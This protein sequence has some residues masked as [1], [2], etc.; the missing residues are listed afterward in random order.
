LRND[1]SLTSCIQGNRHEGGGPSISRQ[2]Q[3]QANKMVCYIRSLRVR[4]LN[5]RL[6]HSIMKDNDE[7]GT[8]GEPNDPNE[9]VTAGP[10]DEIMDPQGQLHITKRTCYYSLCS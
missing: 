10:V 8:F 9:S 4:V 2:P 1:W 6:I 7:I 3:S 5:C